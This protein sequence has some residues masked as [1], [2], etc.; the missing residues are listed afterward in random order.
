MDNYIKCYNNVVSEDFCKEII[1]FFEKKTEHHERE[2]IDSFYS[3]TQVKLQLHKEW[4]YFSDILE[5]VLKNLVYRYV[6]DLKIELHRFPEKYGFEIFRMKRYL[7]DNG[8]QFRTH[9]DVTDYASAKRFL[10]FFIYL[11]N[12]KGGDT[13]FPDFNIK[14]KPKIGKVLMFPPLWTHYHAG[15]KPIKEPK[16]IVGSYL[17]YV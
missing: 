10:V 4:E 6:S 7:P 5:N 11:N 8:D 14:I 3:F 17:H 13:V 2:C 9:V 16:Y 15:L 12:N 1:D